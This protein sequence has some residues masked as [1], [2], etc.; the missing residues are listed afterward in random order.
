MT[1]YTLPG[2]ILAL[3]S[4]A[5]MGKLAVCALNTYSGLD[6]MASNSDGTTFGPI[7]NEYTSTPVSLSWAAA[8]ANG[9]SNGC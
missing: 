1:S 7:P 5:S 6:A 2:R 3:S 8:S 4:E 9:V